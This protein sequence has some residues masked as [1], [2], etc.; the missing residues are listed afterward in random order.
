MGALVAVE[1]VGPTVPL[2]ASLLLLQIPAAMA[3][4]AFLEM[5]VTAP[6]ALLAAAAVTGPLL[7]VLLLSTAVAITVA[8]GTTQDLSAAAG[9]L[10]EEMA[11][12]MAGLAAKSDL[13][14]S[15]R[16]HLFPAMR[17]LVRRAVGIEYAR[18]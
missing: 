16:V 5:E 3:T 7:I 12:P 2:T 1:E 17:V 15:S 10:V 18:L 6:V 9:L 11:P 14:T 8:G 4:R 13:S